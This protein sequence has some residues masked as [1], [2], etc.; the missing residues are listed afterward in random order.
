MPLQPIAFLVKLDR[1]VERRL[2][3]SSRRTISSSR[4]SA[5]S[6]LSWL[7]SSAVAM[8]GFFPPSES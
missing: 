1:L 2:A 3:L 5:A 4:A 8:G 7:T 6:K